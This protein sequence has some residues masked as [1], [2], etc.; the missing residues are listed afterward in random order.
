M[1]KPMFSEGST[2]R[3]HFSQVYL[4]GCRRLFLTVGVL[5]SALLASTGLAACDSGG[6]SPGGPGGGTPIPRTGEMIFA[7]YCNT[8]HPEGGR[9]VGPSLITQDYS[10]PE[11]RSVVRH[12]RKQ[13]PG[14]GV[15]IISDDDLNALVEY[16]KGLRR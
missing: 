4:M 13:M 12:G 2:N 16:V 3:V 10:E 11:M 15:Q 6:S 7:R 1:Q 8:C 5:C 9:G 14:F